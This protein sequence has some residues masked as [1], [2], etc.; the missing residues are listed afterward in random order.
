MNIYLENKLIKNFQKKNVFLL[1][2][3]NSLKIN[4]WKKWVSTAMP[5]PPLEF[6][7]NRDPPKDFIN[8]NDLF[9]NKK[10]YFL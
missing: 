1:K 8:T 2:K 9:K 6:K 3:R 10:V 7:T 5:N 4:I